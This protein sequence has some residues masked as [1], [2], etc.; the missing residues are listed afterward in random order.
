MH[1]NQLQFRFPDVITRPFADPLFRFDYAASETSERTSECLH[2][3][4]L[5]IES[6][7]CLFIYAIKK[8]IKQKL[9]LALGRK[10]R[11]MKYKGNAVNIYPNG[12]LCATSNWLFY[13]WFLSVNPGFL[14]R[15]KGEKYFSIRLSV[16]ASNYL[17]QSISCA[18][19]YQNV[20]WRFGICVL[21]WLK[22]SLANIR[23]L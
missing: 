20:C 5:L 18:S 4:L 10:I 9:L 16:S 6:K 1:F 8:I 13:F 12:V 19:N 17:S 23:L 11:Q 3:K 7:R 21:Q 14:I 15:F 2:S 22:R